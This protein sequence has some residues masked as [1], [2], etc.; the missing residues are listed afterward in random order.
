MNSENLF[1]YH[2][3]GYEPGIF[4]EV[5]LPK[6]AKYQGKLYE[7]LTN[8]FDIERV[9][10]NFKE[11]KEY[12]SILLKNFTEVGGYTDERIDS[13]EPLYW[14]YSMYEVDG[15][16]FNPKKGTVEERTQVIR[17]MFLPEIEKIEAMAPEIDYKVV[18]RMVRNFLRGDSV[19]RKSMIDD[20]PKIGNYINDWKADV[21][22][23]LIGYLIFEICERIKELNESEK[24]PLEEEI[25]LSSFW[26]LEVNK[27]KI[28]LVNL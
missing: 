27:V 10:A 15:V 21:G 18:R 6:K 17:I 8:G 22:L 7:T 26:N 20:H 23:F 19:Q 11:K 2:F 28:S 14:G 24:A 16:F 9:K 5:Y 3:H 1:P 4:A 12:I 13:M 25:W